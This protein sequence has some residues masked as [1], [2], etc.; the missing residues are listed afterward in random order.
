VKRPLR[1]NGSG[2]ARDGDSNVATT[3]MVYGS[4]PVSASL[5]GLIVSCLELVSVKV[6]DRLELTFAIREFG[7]MVSPEGDRVDGSR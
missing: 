5:P 4:G 1:I 6:A 7:V 3:E 2:I